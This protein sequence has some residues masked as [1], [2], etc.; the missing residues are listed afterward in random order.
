MLPEQREKTEQ[1]I[2]RLHGW[3]QESVFHSFLLSGPT[4]LVPGG[5]FFDFIIQPK[6]LI[7]FQSKT[8][9]P[10]RQRLG[11]LTET[12]I[13][14]VPGAGLSNAELCFSS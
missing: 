5:V 14:S 9:K 8:D 13:N 3:E 1:S 12:H 10:W 7:Y 6:L 11:G 4:N 2:S